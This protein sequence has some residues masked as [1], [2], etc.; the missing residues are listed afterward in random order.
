MQMEAKVI[1]GKLLQNFE[2]TFPKGCIL[3][4]VTVGVLQPMG[5]ISCTLRL[6]EQ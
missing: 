2:F 6:L 1:M 3:T 5:D 4:P